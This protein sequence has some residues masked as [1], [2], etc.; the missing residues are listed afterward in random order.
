MLLSG[1]VVNLLGVGIDTDGGKSC[2]KDVLSHE[3]IF[4]GDGEC[5]EK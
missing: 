2:G 1:N 5:L 3:L 4:G